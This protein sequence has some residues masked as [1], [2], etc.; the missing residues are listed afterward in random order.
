MSSREVFEVPMQY[1]VTAETKFPFRDQENWSP[2]ERDLPPTYMIPVDNQGR[3][4]PEWS[5]PSEHDPNIVDYYPGDTSP[6]VPHAQ[7]EESLRAAMDERTVAER[8]VEASRVRAPSD[9][10]I[11]HAQSNQAAC[12]NDE[13]A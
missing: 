5:W 3:P 9:K 8:N 11:N 1:V 4:L 13:R 2:S 6:E 10:A 12:L 7:F